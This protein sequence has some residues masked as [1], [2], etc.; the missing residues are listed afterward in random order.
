MLALLH[1][2]YQRRDSYAYLI[3]VHTIEFSNEK[4]G[5]KKTSAV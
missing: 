5:L 3:S 1:V 4:L 2:S